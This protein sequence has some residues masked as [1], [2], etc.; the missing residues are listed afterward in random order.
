MR[1]FKLAAIV[2]GVMIAFLVVSSV[3]GFMIEAVFALLVVAVVGLA[4]KV[5][6]SR[7]QVSWHRR[8]REIRRPRYSRRLRRHDTPDVEDE[9]T[10]L[11]GEMGG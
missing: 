6:L 10:R 5:A 1:W 9:L 11:K 3:V 4:V 2:V 7:Q 8:D